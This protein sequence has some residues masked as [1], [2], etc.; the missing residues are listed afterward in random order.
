MKIILTL[1]GLALL[2]HQTQ[3]LPMNDLSIIP[4][5]TE[6]QILSGTSELRTIQDII[7]KT[8]SDEEKQIAKFFQEYIFIL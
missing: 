8:R 1:F 7:T 2:N 3:A 4:K 6:T 5:P